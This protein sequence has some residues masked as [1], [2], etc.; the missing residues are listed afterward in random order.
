MRCNLPTCAVAAVLAAASTAVRADR[1]VEALAIAAG[2]VIVAAAVAGTPPREE[3]DA[4]ALEGGRFDPIKNVKPATTL[5]GEYRVGRLLWWQLGPFAGAG[6]TSR[7]SLYGY[8]GIRIATYWA[9][10]IVITPSFAIGLYSRGE[11]KDLGNPPVLGRFGIDVEYRLDNDLRVG[12]AYHHFSNGKVLG[13]SSNPGTE[14][15]GLTVSLPI[16]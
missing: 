12:A 1:E 13:Q 7:Q 14:V 16:R 15:I 6:I 10:R 4:V 8:G 11:G 9:E 2:V 3:A 5:G